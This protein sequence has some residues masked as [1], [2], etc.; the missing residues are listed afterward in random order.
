MGI[1][2]EICDSRSPYF[3]TFVIT[4]ADGSR[5]YAYCYTHWSTID[6]HILAVIRM[7]IANSLM[8][9]DSPSAIS[10]RQL[11]R[12]LLVPT[13]FLLISSHYFHDEFYALTHWY[14]SIHPITP[15]T[16]RSL[17]DALSRMTVYR[18]RLRDQSLTDVFFSSWLDSESKLPPLHTIPFL[19]QSNRSATPSGGE[20]SPSPSPSPSPPPSLS[21]SLSS[22][23]SPH[24]ITV[25]SLSISLRTWLNTTGLTFILPI[26]PLG[27]APFIQSSQLSVLFRCLE[28]RLILYTFNALLCEIPVIMVSTRL[29]LLTP[30]LEGLLSLLY[31]FKW[32]YIYIPILPPS[33]TDMFEAPQPFLVGTVPMSL[34]SLSSTTIVNCLLLYFYLSNF[35]F[36]IILC[37]LL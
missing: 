29:H 37:C 25:D 7:Q 13:A 11:P 31:P 26:T 20:H 19:D 27:S 10:P 2:F 1:R 5:L 15:L 35:F 16:A 14:Y 18:G 4:M 12:S 9:S 17:Y 30:A 6:P 36:S 22:S 3:H 24:D 23:L 34:N 8:M 21:S 33:L 32:P 28:P